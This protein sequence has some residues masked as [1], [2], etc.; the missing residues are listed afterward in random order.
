MIREASVLRIVVIWD[1][2]YHPIAQ[3][4]LVQPVLPWEEEGLGG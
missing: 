1:G 2:W 4:W 3:W